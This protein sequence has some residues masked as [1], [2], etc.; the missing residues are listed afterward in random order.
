M[1]VNY[2]KI[3]TLRDCFFEDKFSET[4]AGIN[5][6]LN[7]KQEGEKVGSTMCL[8]GLSTGI[9]DKI[10]FQKSEDGDYYVDFCSNGEDIATLYIKKEVQLRFEIEANSETGEFVIHYCDIKTFNKYKD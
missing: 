10:Y 8:K 7:S 2:T 1:W 9:I 5:N 4:I 6:L 3:F